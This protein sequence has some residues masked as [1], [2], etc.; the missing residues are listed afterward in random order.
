MSLIARWLA[1]L[2]GVCMGVIGCG[3]H[4]TTGPTVSPRE[5]ESLTLYAHNPLRKPVPEASLLATLP[6]VHVGPQRARRM[7]A[8]C[9]YHWFRM[10]GY[11]PAFI[12]GAYLGVARTADG[13]EFELEIGMYS[14]FFVI[15]GQREF[16]S[17][18]GPPGAEWERVM[19]RANRRAFQKALF[20]PL[21]RAGQDS[22]LR[23]AKVGGKFG[24]VNTAGAV[25]IEARF[26]DAMP[27]SEGLAAVRVGDP[28]EG[29]WG[30]IDTSGRFVIEPRFAGAS[31]FSEGLA[32][33]TVD[34]F[35]DG[36]QGYIDRRGEIVIEPRF[37][38]AWPFVDGVALVLL[39]EGPYS[40]ERYI[41]RRGELVK[42]RY[43]YTP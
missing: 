41:N 19:R 30:Y 24:Y 15:Q 31:F 4:R 10:G 7:F 25:A 22:G 34:D 3:D 16:Y 37:I 1:F 2:F 26:D 14:S 33:V 5:F 17:V 20:E 12:G 18:E 6:H 8:G 29:K 13:R 40:R 23:L 21:S 9:K 36:K 43:P 42:P 27:F 28:D 11:R 35:F 38:M 39:D 32:A